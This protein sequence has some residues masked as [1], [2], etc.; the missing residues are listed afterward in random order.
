VRVGSKR[1]R[2]GKERTNGEEERNRFER[3]LVEGVGVV[4]LQSKRWHL[5]C[6][7]YQ[8]NA[9]GETYECHRAPGALS[10]DYL[11]GG[12]AGVEPMVS[13]LVEGHV[14]RMPERRYASFGGARDRIGGKYEC[15]R[16]R[17]LYRKTT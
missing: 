15:H 1:A 12:T 8:I 3:G 9:R 5:G 6:D 4:G 14:K 17:D 2:T 13:L 11:I 10:Q 7:E 16:A